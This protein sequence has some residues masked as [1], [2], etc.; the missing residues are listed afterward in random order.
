[1]LGYL[2]LVKE[3]M[4]FA[5]PDS[6]FLLACETFFFLRVGIGA[7]SHVLFIPSLGT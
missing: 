1:M 6:A 3:D 2:R 5:F 4:F 7:W